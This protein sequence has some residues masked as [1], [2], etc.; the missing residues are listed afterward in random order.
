MG[1]EN[2]ASI[3]AKASAEANV[4]KFGDV[5]I[6]LGGSSPK[7]EKGAM[8]Y[9]LIA[10]LRQAINPK[11]FAE[12]QRDAAIVSIDTLCAVAERIREF[13]PCMTRD[14]AF[15]SAL[16]YVATNEQAENIRAC[17][18]IAADDIGRD[19]ETT[20]P[21]PLPPASRDALVEESKI[22]YSERDREAVGKLIAEETR[23]AALCQHI[24]DDLAKGSAEENAATVWALTDDGNTNCR[25]NRSALKKLVDYGCISGVAFQGLRADGAPMFMLS[26]K[27][28]ALL[29]EYPSLPERFKI[30]RRIE[31]EEAA[32]EVV[33]DVLNRL[34]RKIRMGKRS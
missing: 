24:L 9:R 8:T 34:T 21:E 22:S 20:N 29:S 25:N 3:D 33:A 32:N 5:D 4:V 14:R 30:D 2:S 7:D 18:A 16:G 27:V 31:S 11:R 10:G 26:S 17:F 12:E 13:N 1:I 6:S 15:L 19:S 23:T 28:E